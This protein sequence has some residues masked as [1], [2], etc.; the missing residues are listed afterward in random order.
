MEGLALG[1]FSGVRRWT[2]VRPRAGYGRVKPH[3]C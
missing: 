2:V 3:K 1:P